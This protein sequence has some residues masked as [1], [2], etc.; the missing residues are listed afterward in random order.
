[1]GCNKTVRGLVNDKAPL[2]SLSEVLT[3][4]EEWIDL[5]P[6]ERYRQVTVRLWG[7]GVVERNEVP[8]AEIAATR[9]RVVRADQFILSRI[10]ARNGAFGIVPCTLDGAVA[11]NDFPSFFINI[12]RLLPAFLGWLSRTQ[13]FVALCK[14]ASEGTTN[15]VRLSETRFLATKIPLPPLPEQRR[16]VARIEALA[17]K[18]AE[19]RG[20]RRQAVEEAEALLEAAVGA[21]FVASEAVENKRLAALASKIGSGSTPTGGRAA[22]PSSGIPFIRSQNVRMRQFDWD[23]IAL[24]SEQTHQAMKGT[25]V[26]PNDVLLNITGASIGRVACAP[27]D[28]EAANVNQHVAIIR[29]SDGLSP[30]Y[31]MYWLSQPSVQDS[32]NDE[33]KGATRQGF[34][35]A[36]I[37][38]FAVPVPS[39]AEQRRIV[40]YLDDLQ[41]KVDA[42]KQLQAETAAELDALLPAVLDK[43]FKGEL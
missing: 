40:A 12:E 38:A 31:L 14:A 33:Q 32:I 43:A 29:P 9:R 15:R 39:L 25:H 19:A 17:A 36:Q 22:Y 10:D 24:I 2:V 16:I 4:S 5:Q 42:L 1:M 18:I 41:A 6:D 28:L 20:L 21:T 23:G 13:D 35:K 3:K 34:T 7:Q 30:R 26:Q 27:A 37:E 11:S 8:G